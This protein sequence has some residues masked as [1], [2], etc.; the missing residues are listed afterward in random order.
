LLSVCP[1]SISLK[2]FII[3]TRARGCG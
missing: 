3:V 2:D 1:F